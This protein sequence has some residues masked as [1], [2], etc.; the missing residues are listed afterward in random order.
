[1]MRK[2][3]REGTFSHTRLDVPVDMLY[4]GPKGLTLSSFQIAE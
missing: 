4:Q 3:T 2:T 1:M